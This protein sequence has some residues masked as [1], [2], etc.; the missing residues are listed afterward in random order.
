M[1]CPASY[2]RDRDRESESSCTDVVTCVDLLF[3][4][5]TNHSLHDDVTMSKHVVFAVGA[6]RSRHAVYIYTL[7]TCILTY[8]LTYIL[9]SCGCWVLAQGQ[10]LD[11]EIHDNTY[12]QH[13]TEG[14]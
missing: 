5:E 14:P 6:V 7:Y 11:I 9:T 10:E 2:R 3:T 13:F 1:A 12:K 8:I 4:R